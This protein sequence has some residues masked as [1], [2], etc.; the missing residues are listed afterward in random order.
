MTES[1]N[2]EEEKPPSRHMKRYWKIAILANIKEDDHPKPEGVPQTLLQILT[3][4]KQLTRSAP[5]SKLMAI[6]QHLFKL[7][8]TYPSPCAM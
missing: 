8:K 2:R 3:I 4:S 5:R 6:Q 7:T 1:F